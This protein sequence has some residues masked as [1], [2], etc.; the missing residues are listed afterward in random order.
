MDP[1]SYLGNADV[2][3][4]EALYLQYTQNPTTVDPTWSHFFKGFDFARSH[5]D[6]GTHP[7]DAPLLQ[8]EF[9]VINLINGYRTRGHLFTH[10]NPVRE[11]RKYFPSL[12][13][14]NFGLEPSDLSQ[15]FHAGSLIGIG[16][17]PLS[18][19]IQH[20][21]ET[22]CRSVGA[23]YKYI[24]NP[25][26]TTWLEQKMESSRNSRNFTL[27]EKKHILQ[28]LNEAVA[29]ESFIHTKFVG[30]KR[31]SL[32]GCETLIPAL[33]AVINSGAHLGIKEFV[34]GMAHRGRLNV[35]ANIMG[36]SYEDIFS[37]FEGLEY[38]E[39]TFAGDVKYHLGY[40]TDVQTK[41][42]A[43]VHLSVAPNP[44]HL[45]AVDPV[46]QGIVR[47]KIDNTPG[48][49]EEMIAPILI[50]GDAAI[51]GQGVVYEV[52]QMSQLR[53]Y[54]T[55]GTIH[56][57]TNNQVGFTT[58]Y[59]DARSSTYCTDVA[60]VTLSPVFHVNA[61]DV[62][63]LIYTVELAME[64][65][66]KFHRDVFIDILGYRKYGHNEGDEPRFTQPL[67]YKAIASHPNPREI[68][69]AKLTSQG[70]VEAGMVKE[71]E[72]SFKESLQKE[73]DHARTH[74]VGK[75][76][77]F[78]EGS[79]S[80]VK[81]ASEK[82]MMQPTNTAVGMEQLMQI[83]TKLNNLPSDKK[84]FSKTAKLFAD[85]QAM[86]KDG[87]RLDWAMAELLAYGT[88]LYEGH[89][90]RFS[91][92]DV[93]RGTF[94]HR[95]AVV[96]VED[97]EEQYTPLGNLRQDQAP[98]YI[99][100]SLLS[101]YAVLGFE[102]GYA[103]ASPNS[104]VIW[105]AQFGD[106]MNGA[107]III[108]QYISSAEDKWRRM[109]GLVMLLPH[110]YEGQGAE[111]SSARLERFL[112]LCA[113]LNMQIVNCTTPANM[114]HVLRR[115]LKRNFRKPLVIFTPKSL[116]RH[117]KC[118]STIQE[119][120]EGHFQEVY[121]DVAASAK[122]TKV[123]LCSGKVYYDLLA[124][125]E[126]EGDG[127]I[128]IIRLEQLYPLPFQQLETLKKKYAKASWVWV[129]E[130]PENMGALTYLMRALRDFNIQ[131]ISR[132]ESASPATGAHHAHDRELR[133]LMNKVF[134]KQPA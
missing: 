84:F 110:G 27:D 48:G 81:T 14:S 108:D 128:A 46:V 61:D 25:E 92:Q 69:N 57:V 7:S 103:L 58:N 8:K 90:V 73:L 76:G 79:W 21:E 113:E 29:F 72:K 31:F 101:E 109:N 106:F 83:A 36:K 18:Q 24:R 13:L 52:I 15:V 2:S 4:I 93:E 75:V 10:T 116:L 77:G 26:I 91:G 130:E 50:H 59:I 38:D 115:Q 127:D 42:G 43:K 3:Q 17:A 32:E 112:S 117:P 124:E 95:H 71:M 23:E 20:L 78:A 132:P 82:D 65:R 55:G 131:Y 60:K 41:T 68:Y 123:V 39:H 94:S 114:F 99:Y 96:R 47:S 62:E 6:Q 11:R 120:A 9:K 89:P 54:R 5:Y 19:I 37:E 121:D 100:N 44:S 64:F 56:L 105:E 45:E 53:G 1:F 126:K 119:F 35:L 30:Q 70:Q 49:N 51:A 98:F 33:D 67:L 28:K 97:S 102:Y 80:G 40:S 22:Y 129:Q 118:V 74:K 87:T 88:L 63:A 125:R 111:H 34:I 86:I 12:E 133:E 104:L 107:Q 134:E 16:D 85:R 66:Q 122:A